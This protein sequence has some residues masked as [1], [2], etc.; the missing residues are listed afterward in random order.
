MGF[1][2]NLVNVSS[3]IRAALC[4]A[5]G[6]A[7]CSKKHNASAWVNTKEMWAL[8]TDSAKDKDGTPLSPYGSP[9]G[10]FAV[11]DELREKIL[12]DINIAAEER[13][14]FVVFGVVSERKAFRR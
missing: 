6:I 8:F 4:E 2:G 13:E 11:S 10:A 1:P 12:A 5:K 9:L 3:D 7:P 14:W